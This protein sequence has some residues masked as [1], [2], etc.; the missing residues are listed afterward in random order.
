MDWPQPQTQLSLAR[1]LGKVLK[2]QE[3]DAAV[4]AEHISDVATVLRVCGTDD[5]PRDYKSHCQPLDNAHQLST[6]LEKA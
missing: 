4:V 2:F 1:D 5:V 6:F 3:K